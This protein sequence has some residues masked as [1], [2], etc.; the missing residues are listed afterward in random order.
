MSKNV[1]SAQ[2]GV[3]CF[4]SDVYRVVDIICACAHK[5]DVGETCHGTRV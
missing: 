5:C 3:Y 4:L 1:S 2:A